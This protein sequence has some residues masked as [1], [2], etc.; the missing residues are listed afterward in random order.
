[1]I[2][3]AIVTQTLALL[4]LILIIVII[5]LPAVL[6]VLTS[7]KWIYILWM[8]SKFTFIFLLLPMSNNMRMKLLTLTTLLF[9]LCNI[10]PTIQSTCS[11]F[12][13]GTLFC[14]FIPFGTLTISAGVRLERLQT[15]SG[16]RDKITEMRRVSL[17]L[18][19]SSCESGKSGRRS[20]SSLWDTGSRNVTQLTG[21]LMICHHQHRAPWICTK[22][23]MREDRLL[24]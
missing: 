10:F 14:R 5:G 23:R 16:N 21:G 8:L 9:A 15:R 6:I 18:D 4:P 13:S 22:R 12:R 20:D 1:M 7:R 17:N 19:R 3:Y 2:T 24:T 11:H